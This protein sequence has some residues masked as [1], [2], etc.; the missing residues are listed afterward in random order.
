MQQLI[1]TA[2]QQRGSLA[3]DGPPPPCSSSPASRN[4]R[5]SSRSGGSTARHQEPPREWNHDGPVQRG[6][7][8]EENMNS[9][10]PSRRLSPCA[11][12]LPHTAPLLAVIR[13]RFR[14]R[15]W[16][17]HHRSVVANVV[18]QRVL[19]GGYRRTQ[20]V[21]HAAVRAEGLCVGSGR[22]CACARALTG[23][24]LAR[25]QPPRQRPCPLGSRSP[26]GP[27]HA[28]PTASSGASCAREPEEQEKPCF[29][30]SPRVGPDV[31]ETGEKRGHDRR[32]PHVRLTSM[33]NQHAMSVYRT[34]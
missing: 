9:S 28:R 1:M 34:G 12:R 13:N 32:A 14:R 2:V 15:S 17:Q 11:S 33:H 18:L 16:R 27:I 3:T 6:R 19:L 22:D 10:S 21:P 30:S 24:G 23:R 7:G 31:I 20:R 26:A 5:W 25:W 29:H 8:Q 4:A